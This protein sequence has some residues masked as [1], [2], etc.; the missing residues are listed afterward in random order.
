LTMFKYKKNREKFQMKLG[1][2]ERLNSF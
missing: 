2:L 1:Y